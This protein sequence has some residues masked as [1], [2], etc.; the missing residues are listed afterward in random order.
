M[1]GGSEPDIPGSEELD[2]F[3]ESAYC[4]ELDSGDEGYEDID[5]NYWKEVVLMDGNSQEE[6]G[7][8]EDEVIGGEV[9]DIS[10]QITSISSIYGDEDDF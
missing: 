8:S 10:S 6:N 3:P 4:E 5:F 7:A 9:V 2:E 1:D